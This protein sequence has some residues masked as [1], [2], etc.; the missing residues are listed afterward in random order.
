MGDRIRILLVDDEPFILKA[1]ARVMRGWPVELH[2]APDAGAAL[3]L[4]ESV[5]PRLLISDYRMPGKTGVE[6]LLEARRRLSP[7]PLLVLHT[8]QP[9]PPGEIFEGMILLEKPASEAQLR[10]LVDQAAA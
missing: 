2:T 5:Q 7:C 1:V 6:L 3:R 10:A 9:I 8:G 4:L